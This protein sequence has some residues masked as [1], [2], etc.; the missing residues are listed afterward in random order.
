MKILNNT[1]EIKYP[2]IVEGQC[3]LYILSCNDNSFYCGS[4]FDLKNRIKEHNVGEAAVWTKKRQPVK[5]VYFEIHDSLLLARR[6][7]KQLKGWTRAKK[8]NLINGF[9]AKL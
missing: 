1:Q 2:E 5:L 9:W 4:T 7:E 6:R 8:L 3:Y